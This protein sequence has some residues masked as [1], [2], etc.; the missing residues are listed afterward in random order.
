MEDYARKYMDIL[1]GI[2]LAHVDR[3][4]TAVFLFGSR[5]DGQNTRLSDVDIGIWGPA[6]LGAERHRILTSIE[7]S[8]VPY[9]VDLVDFHD[10]DPAFRETAIKEIV[11]WNEPRDWTGN[12]PFSR[13]R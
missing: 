7:E 4:T 5:A 2:V 10:A 13:K 11:L 12:A 9:H 3:T 6:P 1:K 8:I